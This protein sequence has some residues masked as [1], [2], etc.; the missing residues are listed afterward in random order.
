[1]KKKGMIITACLLASVLSVLPLAA[2][3]S[4]TSAATGGLFKGDVDN[5]LNYHSFGEVQIDKW[6]GYAKAEN[7]QFALGYGTKLGGL[8][9]GLGYKLEGLTVETCWE[10]VSGLTV[11]MTG[12]LRQR[13]SRLTTHITIRTLAI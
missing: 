11:M 12:M 9:L 1:M 13:K 6:F 2:E 5:Y 7:G 3:E 8:Y 4:S 10:T